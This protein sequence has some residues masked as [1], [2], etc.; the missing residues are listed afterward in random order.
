MH[1][2]PVHLDEFMNKI[3]SN[4]LVKKIE[5]NFSTVHIYEQNFK[6]NFLVNKIENNL[7]TVHKKTFTNLWSSETCVADSLVHVDEWVER[8]WKIYR[9]E[10]LKDEVRP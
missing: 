5:N 1:I 2:K 3:R 10:G 9:L 8:G 7:S 6:S 4:F